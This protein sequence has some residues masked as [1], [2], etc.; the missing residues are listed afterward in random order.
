MVITFLLE[1]LS[2]FDFQNTTF[3]MIFFLHHYLVLITFNYWILFL[4]FKSWSAPGFSPGTSFNLYFLPRWPHPVSIL[5]IPK[6]ISNVTSPQFSLLPNHCLYCIS[7]LTSKTG[8]YEKCKQSQ[9]SLDHHRLFLLLGH[10]TALRSR[11]T[12]VLLGAILSLKRKEER[13][14]WVINTLLLF[15]TNQLGNSLQLPEK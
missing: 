4:I 2:S 6:L 7:N 12:Y 15:H 3:F 13:L 1:T 11:V 14:S 10:P 5:M 8:H 9:A